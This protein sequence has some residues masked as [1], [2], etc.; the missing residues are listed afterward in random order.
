M[1][2]GRD[3]QR[4]VG[5]EGHHLCHEHAFTVPLQLSGQGVAANEGNVDEDRVH[6]DTPRPG[7][8]VC[9]RFIGSNDDDGFGIAP[10][11]V[12]Q[13]GFDRRGVARIH[14]DCRRLLVAFGEG[15]DGAVIARLTVRIVLVDNADARQTK[16]IHQLLDHLLGFLVV[17]GAQVEHVVPLLQAQESRPGKRCDIGDLGVPGHRQGGARRGCAHRSDQGEHRLVFDQLLGVRDGGFRFVGVVKGKEFQAAAE[18]AAIPVDFLE[19]RLDPKLHVLAQ[20][21]GGTAEGGRLAEQDAVGKN[22]G[23][24]V[25]GRVGF[26]DRDGYRGRLRLRGRGRDGSGRRVGLRTP[27]EDEGRGQ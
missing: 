15:C 17:G 12:D 23:I 18:Y 3:W 16:N 14:T 11:Q 19:R 5:G 26:G 20:F 22:A 10:L 8:E 21:L 1:V 27:L 7:N 4:S 13:T 9:D 6:A 24:D 2:G 25:R